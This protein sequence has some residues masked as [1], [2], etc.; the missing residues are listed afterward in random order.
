MLN[1]KRRIRISTTTKKLESLV[2][3]T[4]NIWL[5]NKPALM[6]NTNYLHKYM[7]LLK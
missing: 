5:L 1:N 6:K 4:T 7:K 2:A 3:L